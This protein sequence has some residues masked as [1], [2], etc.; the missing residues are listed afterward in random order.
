LVDDGMDSSFGVESDDGFVW[1]VGGGVYGWG[2]P[3][4]FEE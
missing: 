2:A 4:M 1:R 3:D